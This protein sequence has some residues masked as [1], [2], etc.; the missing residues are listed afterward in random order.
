MI[1][2]Y[3]LVHGKV[4]IPPDDLLPLEHGDRTRGHSHK[5]GKEH[6]K[7][8]WTRQVFRHRVVNSWNSLSNEFV[9]SPSINVFKTN[10][11]NHW[12]NHPSKFNPPF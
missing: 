1:A 10:I 12:K 11:N 6:T 7:L 5:L 2:V 8:H 3:K 9:N 4:D